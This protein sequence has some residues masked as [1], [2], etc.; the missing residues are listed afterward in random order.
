MPIKPMHRTG[1]SRLRR[2]SSVGDEKR[3]AALNVT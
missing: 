1:N 3:Y 2:L